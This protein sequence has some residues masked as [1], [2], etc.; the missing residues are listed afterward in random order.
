MKCVYK[1]FP[2]GMQDPAVRNAVMLT[3]LENAFQKINVID[4]QAVIIPPGKDLHGKS[5]FLV[6]E[7]F[8]CVA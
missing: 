3:R 4:E 2:D 6:G 1:S 7:R 5:Y 8:E